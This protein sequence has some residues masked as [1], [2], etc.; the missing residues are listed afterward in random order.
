[1]PLPPSRAEGPRRPAA[2]PRRRRAGANWRLRYQYVIAAVMSSVP[3]T[4]PAAAMARSAF[5]PNVVAD[6][7]SPDATVT[8]PA[9]KRHVLPKP[10][11][12]R[13][14]KAGG[15]AYPGALIQ[16]CEILSPFGRHL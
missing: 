14:P 1:M 15:E 13:R 9:S 7:R 4:R 6:L 2:I 16:D 8:V 5:M 12:F 3:A 11:G 10:Q